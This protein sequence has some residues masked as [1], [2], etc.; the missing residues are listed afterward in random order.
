MNEWSSTSTVLSNCISFTGIIFFLFF[1]YDE[2][3][4]I[5]VCISCVIP[6][7]PSIRPSFRM[8]QIGSHWTVIYKILYWGFSLKCAHKIKIW[9]TSDEANIHFI[10]RTK[11]FMTSLQI[12]LPWLLLSAHVIMLSIVTFVYIW[13]LCLVT[14]QLILPPSLNHPH[15]ID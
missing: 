11:T 10:W 14:L 5:I 7:C 13:L 4:L 6:P 1:W 2:K 15:F 9:L 3:R 8:A 12:I